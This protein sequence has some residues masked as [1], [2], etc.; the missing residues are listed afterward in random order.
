MLWPILLQLKSRDPE[1]RLKAV[2]RLADAESERAF[3]ALAKAA[4]ED[5]EPRVK[6]AA[7]TALGVFADE[8]AT[9]ILLRKLQDPT[10]EIRLAAVEGLRA[11]MEEEVLNALAVVLRDT[12]SAV[13]GRAS[14]VLD[15]QHWRAKSADDELWHA[16]ARSGFVEAVTK[17]GAKAIGPL[18]MVLS[19]GDVPL[20]VSVIRALGEIDDE[21]VVEVLLPCLKSKERGVCV[22][23][24]EILREFDGPKINEPLM[25]LLTHTDNKVRVAAIEAA[26]W[27]NLQPAAPTVIGLLKDRGWD[28]RTAASVALGKI[29]GSPAVEALVATTRDTDSGVRQAAIAALG[30]IGDPA[31]IPP[32]VALMVDTDSNV[33]ISAG[34][35]LQVINP[36]WHQT[37]A[38]HRMIP[39]LR[40]A[41]DSGAPSICFVAS[42]L[43]QQLG[44]SSPQVVS[45]TPRVMASVGHKQRVMFSTFLELLGDAERDLRLAAVQ[46]LGRLG[47]SRAIEPL[48]QALAD[49]DEAV[50][51][52]AVKSLELLQSKEAQ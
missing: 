10:P 43:L 17:H 20:Q 16:V 31:A 46:V 49:P 33:R 18:A 38:A 28:V 51:R 15:R 22:A 36:N 34:A 40:E 6:A 14:Q 5:T 26:A 1:A 37:E 8:K 29:G 41:C 12:D 7:V 48:N 47:D 42:N 11:R 19:T 32:L 30:K 13:R 52:A 35:A 21:G 24:V 2:Q 3:E 9:E 4:E 27:R 39:V 44:E 23:A 25:S 45:T 50:R